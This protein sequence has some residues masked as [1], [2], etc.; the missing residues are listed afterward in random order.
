MWIFGIILMICG[1]GSSIYGSMLNNDFDSQIRSAFM[2]GY[3][4]PGS[5]WLYIGITVAV[6]GLVLFIVGIVKANRK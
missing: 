4:N 6:I 5:M 1:I 3:T 2:N